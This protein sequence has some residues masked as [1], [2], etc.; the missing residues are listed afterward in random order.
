[1]PKVFLDTNVLAY[2]LDEN[3]HERQASARALVR[4]LGLEGRGVL[5]T[6]ILQEF[7]VCATRKLGVKPIQAKAFLR[8]LERFET[9][10]VTPDL[11]HEAIDCSVLQE[12]SFWDALIVVCAESAH[13]DALWTEDLNS[14]QVI[15]GVKVENPLVEGGKR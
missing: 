1:M 14:G 7:Y 5:S 11:V 8:S 3:D 6:Q 12:I 4:T 15:R 9:V 2:C 10:L 13:C